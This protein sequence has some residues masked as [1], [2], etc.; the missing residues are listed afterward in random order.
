MVMFCWPPT[1]QCERKRQGE[2][3]KRERERLAEQ[4]MEKPVSY[5]DRIGTNLT[6]IDIPQKVQS[7]QILHFILEYIN[8]NQYF[9]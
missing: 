2:E 6:Y 7:H 1:L 4:E 8:L 3:D 9:L 5:I